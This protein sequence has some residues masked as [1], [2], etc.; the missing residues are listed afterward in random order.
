[1]NDRQ[2]MVANALR[3]AHPEGTGRAA[4][5]IIRRALSPAADAAVADEEVSCHPHNLSFNV[6]V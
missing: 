6:E 1:M 2:M 5:E 3:D 4:M